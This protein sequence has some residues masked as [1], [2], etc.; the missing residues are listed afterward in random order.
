M[1]M[2]K[3]AAQSSVTVKLF[4]NL[5]N[6]KINVRDSGCVSLCKRCPGIL[7]WCNSKLSL[8]KTIHKHS[9]AKEVKKTL[10]PKIT[11]D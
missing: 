3:L 4:F 6:N 10:L 1:Q 5:V 8:Y 9:L 11:V 7:V 2:F